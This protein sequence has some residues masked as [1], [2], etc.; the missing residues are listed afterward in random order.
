M[1]KRSILFPTALFFLLFL[2]GCIEKTVY[3]AVVI[4]VDKVEPYQL[5]V[6]DYS[7]AASASGTVTLPTTA[8]SLKVQTGVPSWIKAV[9]I[10]YT[11]KLDQ[12]LP[13][14]EVKETPF[15]LFLTPSTSNDVTVKPYTLKV[16][17]LYEL[18]SS[19]ISPIK[20]SITLK[21]KDANGNDTYVQ[22]TC[23]LLKPAGL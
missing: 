2:T 21:I 7:V 1:L 12:P 4:T 15:D 19:E 11:T 3:P 13:E 5:E 10:V 20:A 6:T 23:L 9:S 16:L 8:V 18:S 17:E 14:L 22:T